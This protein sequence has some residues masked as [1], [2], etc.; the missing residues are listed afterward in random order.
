MTT[1]PG[2]RCA[3]ENVRAALA[4]L[5]GLVVDTE[6]AR[7]ARRSRDFSWFSPILA[8]RLDH[9]AAEAVVSPADEDELKAVLVACWRHEVPLTV[10]GAGTGNRGEAVPLHGG[11]VL[12][13]GYFNHVLAVEPGW[14]RAQAGCVLDVLDHA[15]RERGQALRLHPST[16]ATATL[17]GFVGAG[18]TGVGSIA[19]GSLADT[20]AVRALRVMTLEERPRLL[21]LRGPHVRL[22][23]HG[24][25]TTGV[26][27]EVELP[28]APLVRWEE[29]VLGFADLGTALRFADALAHADAIPKRLVSVIGAPAPGRFLFPHG[30]GEGTHVALVMVAET[31][32][33]ALD[34]VVA[35]HGG[36]ALSVAGSPLYEYAWHHTT[37]HALKHDRGL[38]WLEVAYPGP[39]AVRK[40]TS[41]AGAMGDALISHVEFVR[42]DGVVT[43]HGLPLVRYGSPERLAEIIRAHDAH[44]CTVDD[45]HVWA[46]VAP[47]PRVTAF[48]REIDPK[49]LL[50]PGKLRHR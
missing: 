16:S 43:A 29:R 7:V 15:L 2:P 12:D 17:G 11:I 19:W 13:M 10:R 23:L 1:E 44:G 25:G 3:L 24:I 46:Q 37:L 39:D 38:T 50:N 32:T 4:E 42:R 35:A 48:A 9:L 30:V 49:G 18:S 20:G 34:E 28:T 8:E 22:A 5:E 6:P 14:C 31:A 27:T 41:M 21:E 45:P 40:V 26:I 47:D 33:E 36:E